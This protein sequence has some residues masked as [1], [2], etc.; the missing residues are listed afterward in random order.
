MSEIKSFNHIYGSPNEPFYYGM[1]PSEELRTFL[2][3]NHPPKG[4]ALDI[5][6][7]E[8]RNTLL[9]ARHGFNV[10]AVDIAS[11]GIHKLEKYA[12]EQGLNNIRYSIADAREIQLEPNHYSVIVAV[13]LLDHLTEEEG[14]KVASSLI[15]ALKPNG[16]IC[17]EVFTIHDPAAK[18]SEQRA[19]NENIS[20]T[21]CF[22]KHFF[23]ENELSR[24]FSNLEILSYQETM[25]YDDSH[26]TPHYHGV[27]RLIGRKPSSC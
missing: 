13:T 11:S 14:K 23:K 19:A 20:E 16:F 5:G 22:V 25:K 1:N 8:G 7:G 18:Q 3:T 17:I 10:H 26:G 15:T 24:W 12:L 6:C 27:A 2:E 21:S 4:N 9:L